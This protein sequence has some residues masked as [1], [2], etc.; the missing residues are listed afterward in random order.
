M[1]DVGDKADTKRRAVVRCRVLLNARTFDLL[2]R[3]ALPKGDVLTTAKVAGIW[4]PKTWELI[5]CATRFCC[6]RWTCA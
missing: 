1:V 2:A 4:P 5:P 3:N 6:P